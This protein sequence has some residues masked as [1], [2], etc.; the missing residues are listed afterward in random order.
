[1]R[2]VRHAVSLPLLAAIVLLCAVNAR[3]S[4]AP[5]VTPDGFQ[6]WFASSCAGKLRVPDEVEAR[7]GRFRYVFVGGF[8][9]ERMPGYFSQ[10]ARELRARGVPR[11]SIHF[12][13]P[14]SHKGFEE[15]LEAIGDD[16]RRISAEGPERLVVIAHSRG[17]CDTLAFALQDAQFVADRVE[18]LFLVQGPFGG[19]GVADYVMGE[20]VP[21]DR[22]MPVGS[23]VVVH[24]LGRLE[25]WVMDRGSHGGMAKLTRSAS[26]GFWQVT[27]ERHAAAIP[28]VG[29]KTF[30]VT[31]KVHPSRLRL[32]ARAFARY[33]LTYYGPNDGLVVLEDQSLP[34]LGTDLGPL[35]AG[36]PDL[37]RTSFST[38]AKRRVRKA[39]V[40]SILMAVGQAESGAGSEAEPVRPRGPW[41][42]RARRNEVAG[43]SRS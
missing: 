25:R 37:T 31:A 11:K 16:F 15:N 23:R 10:N 35:D 18:A 38:R 36:H 12:V 17:A 33:L 30:F 19:T 27:L 40:Q 42:G 21:L 7:A 2:L 1:M 29:P 34:G 13:A 24:L 9:N 41:R 32:V 14:S 8:L 6:R 3:A 5:A 39:L 22:R 26:R 20:G 4:S 28:I 43:T